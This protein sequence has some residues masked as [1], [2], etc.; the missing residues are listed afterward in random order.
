MADRLTTLQKL[1]DTGVIAVIRAD[2]GDQL[3]N[4]CRA[5]SAGGVQA[6]EITMTT[7]GALDVIAQ[8]SRE[9]GKSALVGAGSVLD[10]ETARAAILAGARFLFS[11]ILNLDVIAMAHRYDCVAVPG[12]MTPTEIATA[13]TAGA[14]VVKVFPANHFGPQYLRDVHGPL[15]QVKLT[16]T[17]GV[18]LNTAADWIKAGAVAIG[19][20]SSLVK[21][22]L[23]NAG[24]WDGLSSLAKQ[25]VDIVATAR[26]G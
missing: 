7:P 5:L 18:D 15:P 3:V 12:A 21:K 2:S 25:Y 1:I 19:V 6:C 24:N 26:R 8:A 16:P 10:A 20:G 9:L 14:D 23:V 13:W 11:P 4:V 22:D 17:G